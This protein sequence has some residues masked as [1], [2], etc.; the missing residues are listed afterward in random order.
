MISMDI[1]KNACDCE[2]MEE[3]REQIDLIDYKLISLFAKRYEFVKEI[4]KFKEKSEDAIIANDRKKYVIEQRSK[5]AAQF[6]LDQDAYAKI[7]TEL[8]EHNISKELEILE[9]TIK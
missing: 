4:V 9:K 7:F 8:I 3:V 5:W 6:G 1:I 2:S